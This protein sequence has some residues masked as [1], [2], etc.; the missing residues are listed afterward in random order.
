MAYGAF[1]ASDT[2]AK[3]TAVLPIAVLFFFSG[4]S[5]LVYQVVWFRMVVRA[6]GVTVYVVTTV[7]AVFMAGLALGSFCA[8][9][10]ARGRSPLRTYGVLEV[11]V[12][13]AGAAS[14]LLMPLLPGLIGAIVSRPGSGVSVAMVHGLLSCLALLPPTV[15]MG[16]TLPV[17]TGYVAGQRDTL[18]TRG[19]DWA[20]RLHAIERRSIREGVRAHSVL[21]DAWLRLSSRAT[22]MRELRA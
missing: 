21:G 18:G 11:L 9:P 14:S 10:L 15:L 16:A 13:V 6:F 4:V 17:L 1:V 3:R 12:G 5:G 19:V 7:L 22:P 20:R 2:T 8:E